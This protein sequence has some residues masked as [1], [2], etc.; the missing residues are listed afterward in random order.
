MI[1]KQRLIDEER[2]RLLKEQEKKVK[3]EQQVILNKGKVR[4]R[5]KFSLKPSV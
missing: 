3:E 5:L 1:E 4:P 2:R